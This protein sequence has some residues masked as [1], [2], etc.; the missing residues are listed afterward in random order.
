MGL[1]EYSGPSVVGVQDAMWAPLGTFRKIIRRVSGAALGDATNLAGCIA[2]SHGSPM[3]TPAPR[4]IIRR[5]IRW[6]ITIAFP[7]A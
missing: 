4:S 2:S 6:R 1:S 7:L 5:E 3:A